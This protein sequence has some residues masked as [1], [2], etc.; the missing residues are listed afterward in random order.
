[1]LV[2]A[3]ILATVFGILGKFGAVMTSVPAPAL[4]GISLAMTGVLCSI[5]VSAFQEIELR[6]SRN[7]VVI[8]VSIFVAIVM[9]EW[10]RQ[11]PD[12]LRTGRILYLI[13]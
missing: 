6:S 12:S 4:G 10:Q 1:M 13:V 8:G 3:G 5:G 9:A 11:F 7:Q 2:I